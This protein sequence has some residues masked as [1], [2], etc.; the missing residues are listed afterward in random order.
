MDN[1]SEAPR[2]I[3]LPTKK[4]PDPPK[5]LQERIAPKSAE[6][7]EIVEAHKDYVAE[8]KSLSNT[9]AQNNLVKTQQEKSLREDLI[10]TSLQ[11]TADV[12]RQMAAVNMKL[13]GIRLTANYRMMIE[14]A[15]SKL[16]VME[17]KDIARELQPFYR[18]GKKRPLG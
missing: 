7:N 3:E 16:E 5:S 4:K 8:A 2:R 1:M 18:R 14:W 12:E 13:A 6:S 9:A 15:A 17:G 10:R 11:V